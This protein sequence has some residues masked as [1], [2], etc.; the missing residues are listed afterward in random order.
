MSFS[1]G[2]LEALRGMFEA[3]QAAN[4]QV[5][6]EN[7]LKPAQPALHPPGA[8]LLRTLEGQTGHGNASRPAL[9]TAR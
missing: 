3:F 2:S 1:I 9:W 5:G 6:P 7:Q 4:A 8:R